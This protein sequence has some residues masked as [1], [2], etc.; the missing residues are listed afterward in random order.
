MEIRIE[1]SDK[2]RLRL[3]IALTSPEFLIDGGVAASSVMRML[4]KCGPHIEQPP[5][6]RLRPAGEVRVQSSRPHT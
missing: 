5:T 2:R 4:Q 3:Q 6:P 1:P